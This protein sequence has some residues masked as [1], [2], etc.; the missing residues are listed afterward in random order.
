MKNLSTKTLQATYGGDV[1]GG[2]VVSGM[3]GA[4][5]YARIHHRPLTRTSR[6]KVGYMASQSAVVIPGTT[7]LKLRLNGPAR[8][9][10][11]HPRSHDSA[12][13]LILNGVQ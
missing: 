12:Y 6:G 10:H 1:V 9:L 13:N 2:S 8:K 3:L 5:L 4:F 7:I 11:E